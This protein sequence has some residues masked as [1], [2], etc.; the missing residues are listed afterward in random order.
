[1]HAGCI[2][3]AFLDLYINLVEACDNVGASGKAP[4]LSLAEGSGLGV[5]DRSAQS[6]KLRPWQTGS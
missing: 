1:M 4:N 2:M 3:L 5:A 6:E